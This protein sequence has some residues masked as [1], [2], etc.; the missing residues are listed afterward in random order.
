VPADAPRRRGDWREWLAD[1]VTAA[2]LAPPHG[3]PDH[4][5]TRADCEIVKLQ[6]KVVVGRIA[7][8]LG[9]L[10]VK[11][12][13][14]FAWRLAAASLLRRSPAETAWHGARLLREHGFVVPE[15]LGALER[16]RAGLLVA[17]FFV[18]RD[19]AGAETADRRWAAILAEPDPGRRRR[20]R[21]ALA[22][23]LGG[24]FRRL[25]AAGIYHGDL[26]D[27]NVLVRGPDDAPE[28]VLL[29]LEQV[30]RVGRVRTARCEK[31]LV[32]L[33]RTL[34]RRASAT[35]RAR[36]L[37]SYL[38][39]ADRAMRRAWARAVTRRVRRKDRRRGTTPTAAAR[40]PSV[41]CTVICQD[42]EDVLRGCLASVA[43]CDEIV[44]VDGGS[45]DGTLA[46]A[47]AFTDRVLTHA[48]PGY[49]AQKQFALDHARSEWV[50]NVDADE[51][52]TPELAAEMRA[53]LA[54]VRDDVGG[55]AVPRLVC[56]LGRWWFRGDWYPRR[57]VRL[58]RRDVTIWGGTDPHERAEPRGT[59]A[60]LH[61]P[62]IHYS[63]ADIADHLRS[64]NKLTDVAAGQ[65]RLPGHIGGSRLVL[66]PA[67]RFVRAG[68]VRGGVL[69]GFP[70]LFVAATGAFYVF[71]R[72]AKVWERRRRELDP[73]TGGS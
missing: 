12:H 57:V 11:R 8:P 73:R 19:V 63:Y 6:P 32:Q 64:V 25:H 65:A 56:Y 38:P 48:W 53:R 28:L 1:G 51:R 44:V 3:N 34:G 39:D 58:V 36:F 14:V 71:L 41:T 46:L 17:S 37:R 62:L 49:R 20:A 24:L 4:L 54:V 5:L 10:W 47:R 9:T 42:E 18:T 68:I 21:R 35:D 26:K 59:V 15:T 16:R 33:A 2:A 43:W 27:V 30:H 66:E 60:P 61:W 29:D 52:V 72:W 31:N 22:R 13:T 70:G 55:F 50:L 23:A 40:V 45:R 69:E 67:W 7:T